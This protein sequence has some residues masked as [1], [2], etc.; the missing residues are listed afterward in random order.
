MSLAHV[1]A[2]GPRPLEVSLNARDFSV[3]NISFG[4]YAEPRVA[5]LPA[6]GPQDGGTL[7]AVRSRRVGG[8]GNGSHYLCRF[9]SSVVD[10][11]SWTP[12]TAAAAPRT[13]Q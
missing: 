1:D 5:A 12:R 10:A 13:P 9:G 7:V 4:Y 11:T 3:S 6:A 2:R 8:L